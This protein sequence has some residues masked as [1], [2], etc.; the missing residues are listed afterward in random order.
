MGNLIKKIKALTGDETG[1]EAVEWIMIVALLTVIILAA[2]NTRLNTAL[3]SAM[4][5]ITAH[6]STA[7]GGG[8]G[9]KGNDGNNG[10]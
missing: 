4:T 9:N 1:A 6:V 8:G 3:V 2:Y 10:N 7:A 5:K